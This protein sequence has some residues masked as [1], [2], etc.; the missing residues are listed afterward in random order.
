M[1]SVPL[2]PGTLPEATW[3]VNTSS[4]STTEAWPDFSAASAASRITSA[5][6]VASVIAPPR[7]VPWSVTCATATN[8]T[9]GLAFLSFASTAVA[10][11]SG[12]S[13]PFGSRASTTSR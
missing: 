2:S 8:V 6:T 11:V 5:L 7:S 12:V 4:V 3:S 1:V 9:G 10:A 13:V